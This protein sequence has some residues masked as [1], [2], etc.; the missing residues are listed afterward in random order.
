MG[1]RRK[2]VIL[3]LV[4]A[5]FMLAMIIF[6][7]YAVGF[8]RA[9]NMASDAQSIPQTA[10]P[11]LPRGDPAQT[12]LFADQPIENPSGIKWR[13]KPEGY[14]HITSP[15]AVSGNTVFASGDRSSFYAL[16]STTGEEKWRFKA[17]AA[18]WSAPAASDGLVFFSEIDQEMLY[19]VDNETGDLRWKWNA[20]VGRFSAPTISDGI[21][22]IGN[23]QGIYAIDAATGTRKWAFSP[24]NEMELNG[25]T[26]IF[27]ASPAVAGKVVYA[28]S[29]G[30]TLFAI[31]AVT[32][33]EL[34]RYKATIGCTCSPA[35]SDGTVF[36]SNEDSD[37]KRGGVYAIDAFSGKEKWKLDRPADDSIAVSGGLVF[38]AADKLY[39]VDA[40]TGAQRWSFEPPKYTSE[41]YRNFSPAAIAGGMIYVASDDETLHALDLISGEEKWN[42]RINNSTLFAPEIRNGMIFFAGDD[43]GVGTLYAVQ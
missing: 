4:F 24:P 12:G 27:E 1:N 25:V 11:S 14:T 2:L 35:V 21:L 8:F 10:G 28:V 19:A 36:F 17:R 20:G 22:Y 30:G 18:M 40:A 33:Q 16:D 13:Y 39:A 5:V 29:G 7:I 23:H 43:H 37:R 42:L 41:P 38:F 31:D 26:A 32:G 6:A 3:S 15:P 34:W 9:E